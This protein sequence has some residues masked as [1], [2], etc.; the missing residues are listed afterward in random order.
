MG[1][2]G[3]LMTMNSI[4]ALYPAPT[5]ACGSVQANRIHAHTPAGNAS[6]W[7]PTDWQGKENEKN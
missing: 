4:A 5:C 3:N 2:V 6:R 7:L 1:G